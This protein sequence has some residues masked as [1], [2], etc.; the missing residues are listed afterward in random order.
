M[1]ELTDEFI[2]S[3]AERRGLACVQG[4]LNLN[5]NGLE[6]GGLV[7]MSGS[8][9]LSD[10]FFDHHSTKRLP[11]VEALHYDFYAYN[12]AHVKWFEDRGC[13]LVKV[14]AEPGDLI[15]ES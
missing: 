11:E 6:D 10:E 2:S 13:K 12:D 3:A 9:K 5:H 14:C 4:I 15:R 1:P 8:A 7:V